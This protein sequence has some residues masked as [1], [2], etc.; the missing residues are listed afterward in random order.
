MVTVWTDSFYKL[1]FVNLLRSWC[2]IELVKKSLER[3]V[4]GYQ[5]IGRQLGRQLGRQPP[6]WISLRLL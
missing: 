6:L 5:L 1:I 4:L 2:E 3:H